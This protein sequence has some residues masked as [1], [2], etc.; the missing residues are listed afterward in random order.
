[1]SFRFRFPIALLSYIK[2]DPSPFGYQ[3][4]IEKAREFATKEGK[5]KISTVGASEASSKRR[6]RP[7]LEDAE[8][9][10]KEIVKADQEDAER[11]KTDHR[12]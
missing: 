12:S 9:Y 7:T 1:M 6:D 11:R 4:A 10:L 5:E 2:A 8:A 3:N